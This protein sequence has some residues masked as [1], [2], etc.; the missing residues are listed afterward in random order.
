MFDPLEVLQTIERER[1]NEMLLVP[2]MLQ[3][4][5]NHP[6]FERHDLSCL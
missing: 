3:A 2:T 1:I 5:I 6:D 4:V